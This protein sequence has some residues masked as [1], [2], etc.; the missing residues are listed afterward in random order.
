M[1]LIQP[2]SGIRARND[3]AEEV[4]APPY[5]VLSEAEAREIARKKPQSFIHVTRSEVALPEGSDSH[6]EE[7][8]AM[9]KT[10]LLRLLS[11]G[12]L[13]Q[14]DAPCFYLY[15][16][17]MGSHTQ[18]GLMATC[19][20]DEYDS[21]RIKKHEYTR[22]DKEQDRVNHILGTHAQTGLVFLIHKKSD[23]VIELRE[24][25]LQETPLFEVRTEDGVLHQL[26][27]VPTD[28][29]L[30]WQDAFA[31]F[32]ALYIADGHHRSAAASRV[33]EALKGAGTSGFFLAGIFPEDQ[34]QVLPYNRLVFDLNGRDPHAF[35][36]AITDKFHVTLTDSSTPSNRGEIHMYLSGQWHK[37]QSKAPLSDDPVSCLDVAILQDDLLDPLLG[38]KDPRRDTRIQFVGGIRGTDVLET[39][40]DS[41]KAAVAFSLY[42]TGLDQLLA[43]ADADRVMPPKSTW[44]EPKLAGGIVL[45]SLD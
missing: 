24:K 10:Q 36:T 22:P 33:K 21:G 45:H 42:P 7:A 40:V 5:D 32:Q 41:G 4:I 8:Y 6:G 29:T 19:S 16:Q 20:V 35:I 39:A 2:F 27:R 23:R 34:L 9:A 37:L 13:V 25:A 3:K 11:E 18:H 26:R 17:E 44:F 12:A 43:V 38:I 1:A 28:S 30:E 31:A 15:S 14:D